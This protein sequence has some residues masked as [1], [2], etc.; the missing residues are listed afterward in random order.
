MLFCGLRSFL[1]LFNFVSE[2]P[3]HYDVG[4][5]VHVCSNKTTCETCGV[6][7]EKTGTTLKPDFVWHNIT[8]SSQLRGSIVKFNKTT[9]AEAYYQISEVKAHGNGTSFYILYTNSSSEKV[10]TAIEASRTWCMFQI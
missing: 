7:S 9:P 10:A 3:R 8:C 6:T 2:L 4:I 5:E 1:W